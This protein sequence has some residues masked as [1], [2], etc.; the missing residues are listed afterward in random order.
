MADIIEDAT[1][2]T[3][4]STTSEQTLIEI[5]LPEN[6]TRWISSL[7]WFA[8]NLTQTTVFR[9]Y[10]W[11][12]DESTYELV[13]GTTGIGGTLTWNPATSTG[14]CLRFIASSILTTGSKLKLTAQSS[15]AEGSSKNVR[16]SFGYLA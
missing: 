1:T 11:N 14:R 10:I 15:V 4:T 13:D 9:V 3:M 5:V 2:A 6:A 8:T 16:V 7:F 12:V